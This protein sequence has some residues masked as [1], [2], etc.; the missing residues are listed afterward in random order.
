MRGLS[1]KVVLRRAMR[2]RLPDVVIKRRKRGFNAPVSDW[3]RGSLRPLCDD[4]LS[5]P[6]SLVDVRHPSIQQLWMNH[7][8]GR[9]DHGF[10]LWSLI[11]LLIWERVL[12]KKSPGAEPLASTHVRSATI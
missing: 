2:R 9:A 4:L 10:R 8:N 11:T 1:R 7:R 3:L 5:V 12:S 6:S